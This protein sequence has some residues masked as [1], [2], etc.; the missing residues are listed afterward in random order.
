MSFKIGYNLWLL[1][2]LAWPHL[3]SS[4]QHIIGTN[5]CSDLGIFSLDSCQ[6]SHDCHASMVICFP[7]DEQGL[8]RPPIVW[9]E[10][11]FE[12]ILLT[13]CESLAIRPG[14]I[15][16]RILI[17]PLIGLHLSLRRFSA[18]SLY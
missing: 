6:K 10:A 16:E 15:Q 3:D 2:L 11:C 14:F 5:F 18:P 7:T 17:Q 8:A 13:G 9:S 4:H 12:Y 1:T